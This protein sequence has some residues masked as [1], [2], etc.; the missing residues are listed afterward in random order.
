MRKASVDTCRLLMTML[1]V[2]VGAAAWAQGMMIVE[3]YT[4]DRGLPSNAVY[5]AFKDNDNFLWLG[6]WHGLT[7]FD[8]AAFR[9]YL[10]KTNTKS[11]LPP[12]KVRNVVADADGYL[13][14]R[15]TDNHLYVFDKTTEVYHDVYKEL[16]SLSPNVQVIKVQRMANGH[17]VLLTRNKNIYEARI[18]RGKRVVI[19]LIHDSRR[20][21]D[22][23][24]WALKHHVLGENNKYVYWISR[25]LDLQVMQKHT[26]RRV[27]NGWLKNQ[28][29][30]CFAAAGDK[31]ACVGTDRG[32]VYAVNLDNGK[33]KDYSSAGFDHAV[34]GVDVV[35]GEVYAATANGLYHCVQGTMPKKVAAGYGQLRSTYTDRRGLL[36]LFTKDNALVC[37]HAATNEVQRF[38]LPADSLFAEMKF[39]DAGENG[40]FMLLR[41]GEVWRYDYGAKTMQNLNVLPDFAND[42]QKPNF[43]DINTDGQG[44]LWLSS[45]TTGLYKVCF[46]K[47]HF[48]FFMPHLLGAD[49][50]VVFKSRNGDLWVGTRNGDLYGIDA[51]TGRVKY[52]FG[53]QEIGVVYHVMEDRQGNLWFSTKGSGL[54]KATTDMLAPQG[55]RLT[56][57]A[58]RRGDKTSLSSNRV[59]YTCQDSRGRI[60][61]CTFYGG[62]N[63]L[64]QQKDGTVVF[65]HKLNGMARYPRYGMYTD[66]RCIT[67]DAHGRMWVATTDGLMSFD[68]RFGNVA[69]IAFETYRNG[70]HTGAA[71]N[72]IYTMYKDR[73]G[74]IWL[75]VFGNGLNLLERYDEQARRPVLKNY[76]ICD[77]QE[78]DVVNSIVEDND[79][80]LWICTDNRLASMSQGRDF[81]HVYDRYLGFPQVNIED[82]AITCLA[83]G[84]V[85]LGTRQGLLVFNTK[86]VR[87]AGETRHSTYIVGM[88]VANKDLWA[89]SPPIYEGALK[90]ADRVELLYNQATFT[91]EFAA[92]CYADDNSMKYT[93][94]L[95]GYEDQWHENGNNRIASYANVPPGHYQFRVKV[96]DGISPERVIDIVILPPWWAT[97]WAYLIYIVLFL[98]VLYGGLRLLFYTVRMRNEVYINNR[99]AELK[100][101]FFTNV[102]HELRTPLSLIKGPIEELK[103]TEQLTDTGKEYLNLIDRNAHKMLQ[104]VNQILDFR[105]IQNGKMKLHVSLVD[106][107]GIIE[108]FMQE[109]KMLAEERD[110]AFVFEKPAERVMVWCDAEKIGVVVNNLINNAFKYTD[111]G[112]K[113]CVALQHDYDHKTCTIRVEDDGVEI[114]KSQLEQI[115]ERFSQATNTKVADD[116]VFAGTGIGLSLSREYVN[117]HHG[118]IWAENM[119]IGKGVVFS[120]LLHIDKEHYGDKDVEVYFDD[121][122][123]AVDAGQQAADREEP[124]TTPPGEEQGATTPQADRASVL[125]IED[126]IDLCRM[127][128]LQL[129][130]TYNIYVAHQ[131]E[132]GLKK[133]YQYHPDVIVTDLMMPGV[134]GME[135]LQR[136]RND[137]AIS[138]IPVVVLTAKNS[139]EDKMEAT[140][141]GANAFIAKPFSSS[142]LQARIHQLLEEQRIFQR[143]MVVQNRVEERASDTDK[144]EYEQH[145][146]KKDIEFIEKIHE[147]IEANLNANDFNIDTIAETIGLSRSAFFKKLKSLTGFAPVD[148]VKEI[149]LTK[150]AKLME[151]T[152]ANISEIAYTVGFRDAGY[153]GKCFRKKYGMSP[154]EYKNS[155]RPMASTEKDPKA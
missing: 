36:W 38:S 154:K 27:L 80:C 109:Y 119:S 37:Y 40:L 65:R 10:T 46:P 149:R 44:V 146:V 108:M 9:P 76:I 68:G 17:I 110:I 49:I 115:F 129:R 120:V 103:S 35:G 4:K 31:Y 13:W 94:I 91:I 30:T 96:D 124:E 99:L 86:E 97:W 153:F 106:M 54:V 88:K 141:L 77:W 126:N 100:I 28:R 78:G 72:D 83:D 56:R 26:S 90:Y 32:G 116:A 107:N 105:K 16:K 143:K 24:T 61:V 145:L 11:D 84:T 104:L 5:C 2:L 134:G 142:Y 8:G 19:T 137:F 59:Y 147:V 47:N 89:Y 34:C 133:I 117:M 92:P 52:H 81:V 112:G 43:F 57:Y 64:Q 138:H 152:D 127:L 21:I 122:T 60:W 93:Y 102:S 123:A 71:V 150:A 42:A 66:V 67:E 15:N 39:Q 111:E 45:I 29:P 25:Q 22:H 74:N 87:H 63:L 73:G 18:D 148:L 48:R 82:N 14:V 140:R 3:H 1:L 69:D 20:D 118:K 53:K 113:I 70:A 131:G 12:R 155:N 136:V 95:D 75:G 55:L 7:S 79:H 121:G 23:A 144:D 125:V 41:N 98:L 58:N 135:L 85:L 114:P 139:D 132:E 62:L 101:R 128:Q 151:T 51:K 33:V 6:T 50:R 130:D